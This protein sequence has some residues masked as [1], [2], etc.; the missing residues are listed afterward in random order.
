MNSARQHF[1]TAVGA[2]GALTVCAGLL[3]APAYQSAPQIA[4]REMPVVLQALT[5]NDIVTRVSDALTYGLAI[6]PAWYLT[7][8]VSIPMSIGIGFGLADLI[9]VVGDAFGFTWALDQVGRTI[10]GLG[11]AV[12]VYAFG[13][14]FMAVSSL[15]GITYPSVLPASARPSSPR[16]AAAIA[17]SAEGDSASA[18]SLI[19]TRN[20]IQRRDTE[21]ATTPVRRAPRAAAA[22]ANKSAAA[23]TSRPV[24]KRQAR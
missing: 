3:T 9:P 11:L 23:A 10:V 13:P 22:R 18:R 6:A 16:S 24:T 7:L 5:V 19:Q 21:S 2:A 14:P 4:V 8:P 20:P 12:A 15:L 1:N 17:R